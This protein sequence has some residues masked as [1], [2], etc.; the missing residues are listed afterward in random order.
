MK[1]S[2][3][4]NKQKRKQICVMLQTKVFEKLTH[5]F[6]QGL[7]SSM[8]VCVCV[9]VCLKFQNHFIKSDSVRI[10]GRKRGW[11]GQ[12]QL[13]GCPWHHL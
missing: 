1:K 10:L 4:T 11:G 7:Q 8:C 6:A 5:T 3:K 12:K 2:T 9:C 13:R